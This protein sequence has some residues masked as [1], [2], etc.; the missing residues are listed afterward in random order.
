MFFFRGTVV[1]GY[2]RGGSLLGFPTANIKLFDGMRLDLTHG[3]Y[4]G[5]AKP[6]FESDYIMMVM[7]I[8]NN[9]HFNNDETSI[10]VHLIKEYKK[11]F[12]GC[13][14]DIKIEGYVRDMNIK[15]SNLEELKN[16]I[17]EDI[18]IAISNL[19]TGKLT[20]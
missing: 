13:E 11:D 6:D 8:G 9:P 17:Q 3:V 10:E 4:Y 1:S 2:G 19:S 16:K 20:Y 15:F 7:S 5:W 14:M 18:D 12:Y